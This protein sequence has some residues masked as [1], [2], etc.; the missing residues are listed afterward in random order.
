LLRVLCVLVASLIAGSDLAAQQ[1][2]WKVGDKPPMLAGFRLAEDPDSARVRLGAGVQVDTM[3]LAS[4]TF[5]IT[6]RG[7]G[8]SLVVSRADGVAVIYA[9][10]PE[11]GSLDSIRVGDE[12]AAVLRRWGQPTT[13]EG[14]TALWVVGEWVVVVTLN[15]E[16]RVAR[17]GVG[18]KA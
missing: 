6:H 11:A 4:E 13:A 15:R 8:I 12:S 16:N 2:P 17:I 1:L 9:D 14:E 18:R 5:G 7:K 10:R 3:D